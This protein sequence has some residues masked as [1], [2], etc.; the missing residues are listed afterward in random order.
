LPKGWKPFHEQKGMKPGVSAVSVFSGWSLNNIAWYSNLTFQDVIK[1]WLSHF[2][3]YGIRQA[4]IFVDPV[5]ANYIYDAGFDSKEKFADYL[6]K[7][8]TTPAWLYW[9][10][11]ERQIE[12]GKKGVEPYASYLKLGPNAD[13]PESRYLRSRDAAGAAAPTSGRAFS[14]DT[15][16][17]DNSIEVVVVGGGTNTYWSGGD[18]GYLTTAVIDQWR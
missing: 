12:Q 18:F 14:Q 7:N 6:A 11:R 4:T 3:S 10:R 5:T 1:H 2:F 8:S 9:Q 15:L 17:S 16:T 13:I